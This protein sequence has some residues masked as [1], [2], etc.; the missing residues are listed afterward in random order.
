M[1]DFLT[2]TIYL[3]HIEFSGLFCNPI[4]NYPMDYPEKP[5]HSLNLIATGSASFYF[6]DGR[7]LHVEPNQFYYLPKGLPYQTIQKQPTEHYTIVFDFLEEESKNYD[8]FAIS[9]HDDP[10]FLYNFKQFV[11]ARRHK[12]VGYHNQCYQYFYTLINDIQSK[13]NSPYLSSSQKEMLNKAYDYIQENLSSPDLTVA[14]ICEMLGVS[15]G[16]FRNI[17]TKKYILSPKK[18]ITTQRLDNACSLLRNTSLGIQ[19]ISEQSGFNDATHF[20]T[21]FKKFHNISPT[22]YRKNNPPLSPYEIIYEG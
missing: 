4:I 13:M 11:H 6:Y 20:S 21:E 17:F 1:N 16:Y 18:Y 22:D 5:F 19:E 14:S 8:F 10:R 7:E 15:P 3:T 2:S 12:K 9:V